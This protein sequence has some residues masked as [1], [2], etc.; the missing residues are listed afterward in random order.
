MIRF[1]D[2]RHHTDD[3]AGDRFAFF[4]TLT[5][6]FVTDDMGCQV[7]ETIGQFD[8]GYNGP[9]KLARFVE[10][11][12]EW[13]KHAAPD[14]EV[15]KLEVRDGDDVMP[16]AH[17]QNEDGSAACHVPLAPVVLEALAGRKCAYFYGSQV[18]AYDDTI[19]AIEGQIVIDFNA[20]A[21]GQTW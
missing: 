7:W 3:L 18:F 16:H 1:I 12:P 11:T 2:L 19:G 21:E 14:R 6:T 20:E 5:N 4:D 10:L 9:H 15:Y 8:Q 17:A 13:A